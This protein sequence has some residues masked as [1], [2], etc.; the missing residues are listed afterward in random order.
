MVADVDVTALTTAATLYGPVVTK[1]VDVLRNTLGKESVRSATAA[2]RDM[3]HVTWQAAAFGLA[4]ILVHFWD[5]NALPTS[6][7]GHVL[8]ALVVGAAGSGFHELFSALSGIQKA[9]G[10]A[11]GKLNK[12]ASGA[13]PAAGRP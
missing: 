1:L 8:T 12:K 11:G 6:P 4:L 5:L 3:P 2:E 13:T 10:D 7:A 9:G